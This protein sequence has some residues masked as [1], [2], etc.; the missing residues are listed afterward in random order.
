MDKLIFFCQVL[1]M[2][3]YPLNPCKLDPEANLF[4]CYVELIALIIN[5][6]CL[7]NSNMRIDTYLDQTQA[8]K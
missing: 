8:I 6:S 3:I 5:K 7:Y 4:N 1:Y 2:L